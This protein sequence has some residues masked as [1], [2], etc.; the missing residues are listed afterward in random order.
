[1]QLLAKY[2]LVLLG[3]FL[4]LQAFLVLSWFP[5]FST[6]LFNRSLSCMSKGFHHL[7]IALHADCITNLPELMSKTA[8]LKNMNV[9]EN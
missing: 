3:H 9:G 8:I 4:L 7:G 2:V 1:M 5:P 6:P